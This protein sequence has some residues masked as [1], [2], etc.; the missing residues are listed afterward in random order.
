MNYTITES[1]GEIGRDEMIA[2]GKRDGFLVKPIGHN[3]SEH[4]YVVYDDN[5]HHNKKTVISYL[6]DIGLYTLGRFGEWE[7]Y[8]MDI[9]IK[10]AINMSIKINSNGHWVKLFF[11]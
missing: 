9:C 8:N 2:G 5:Y 3:I 7:Y 6:D 10:S 4:A 1:V 11:V